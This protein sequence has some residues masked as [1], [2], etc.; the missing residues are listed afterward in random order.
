MLRQRA[1]EDVPAGPVGYEVDILVRLR[2][3][4][5][6]DGAPI[7]FVETERLA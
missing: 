7:V 4:N 2:V 6:G 3:E 5:R 1:S